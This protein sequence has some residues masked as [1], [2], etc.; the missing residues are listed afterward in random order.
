MGGTYPPG[1][2]FKPAVALAAVEAGIATPD[3]HV[4]CNGAYQ[5]RRPGPFIAGSKGGHGTLDVQGALQHSCNV[6]FCETS[7]R[8]GIDKIEQMA[9]KLGLGAP[10]GIELPGERGGPDPQPGMEAEDLQM[11]LAAGRY[12]QRRHRPGLCHRHAAAAC[13]R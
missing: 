12:A 9:R 8:L 5:L 2:T 3:Y 10:T 11:G 1:S 7:R 13:A 6:F 4:T